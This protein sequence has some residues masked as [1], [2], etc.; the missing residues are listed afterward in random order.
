VRINRNVKCS[1]RKRT[2]SKTIYYQFFPDQF[3]PR[4]FFPN[5]SSQEQF[6]PGQFFLEQFFPEQF[7]PDVR[8][9]LLRE[10]LSREELFK[11]E[12]FRVSVSHSVSVIS[13][14]E[15]LGAHKLARFFDAQYLS[16]LLNL[17]TEN[18]QILNHFSLDFS[19]ASLDLGLLAAKD[20]HTTTCAVKN[21]PM[22][23]CFKWF[24]HM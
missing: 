16:F 17:F 7:F 4:Q 23:N 20:H 8:E 2:Y 10:E 21:P 14:L 15:H 1:D 11:E 19:L 22:K 12:L 6:F 9:K 13:H 3:F 18:P 5:N 24:F